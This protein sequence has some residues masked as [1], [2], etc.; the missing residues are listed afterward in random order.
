[1]F[2]LDDG[3]LGGTPNVILSDVSHIEAC[4]A[5][6]GLVLNH[7]KSEVICRDEEVKSSLLN[8]CPDMH[9]TDPKL[10]I[11][12]GSPIGDIGAIELAIA[13]KISDLERMGC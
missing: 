1:M 5:R 7:S 11:L 10:A 12:L 2:Y 4:S 13:S 6:L 9:Y 8:N 3:T